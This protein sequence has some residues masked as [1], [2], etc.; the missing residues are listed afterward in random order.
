M[1]IILTICTCW[2]AAF[3]F[4]QNLEFSSDKFSPGQDVG[5]TYRP[6]NELTGAISV[7]AVVFYYEDS[8]G[9]PIAKE[10][11][12]NAEGDVFKGNITTTEATK[13]LLIR[14]I[15]ED[16]SDFN[17]KKGYKVKMHNAL[18]E[19]VQGALAALANVYA[20][21]G[22]NF[23]IEA[24]TQKGYEYLTRELKLYPDSKS[25]HLD[26][27]ARLAKENND[28]N[29]IAEIKAMVAKL[30]SNKKASESDLQSARVI[31]LRLG[32][33]EAVNATRTRILKDY[34]KGKTVLGEK[35]SSFY[36]EKDLI[37]KE[38]IFAS[39]KKDLDESSLDRMASV[40]ATQ[41]KD[42]KTKF[43]TYAGMIKN[44]RTLAGVYNS[45]AWGLSGESIEGEARDL[46]WAAAL[47]SKSLELVKSA[48]E[49]ME[50]KPSFMTDSDW[51]KNLKSTYSM[52]ADT[53]AL[54]Q[55]KR[56]KYGDALR[57]QE[58]YNKHGYPSADATLRHA[59]YAE[60]V[61]GKDAALDIMAKAIVEGNSNVELKEKF[62]ALL[63]SLPPEE[64]ATKS[65]AFLEMQAMDKLKVEIAKQMINK[66]SPQFALKDLDGNEVSL[67]SLKGKTVVIDF[68]ATWCGPCI[69]SFPGM[70]KAVDKYKD[71]ASVRFL[72]VDSWERM[73]ADKRTDHVE[74][75]VENKGY[76]F[77]VLMDLDDK[78]IKSYGVEGIPT[79]FV[80]GPDGNIKFKKIGGGDAEKLVYELYTMIDLVKNNSAE[81]ES[82]SMVDK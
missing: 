39:I 50:G 42:N 28:E 66:E 46:D 23:G 31:Y 27:Y 73:G 6:A 17:S 16:K 37:K 78:V 76:R 22:R 68:W 82:L 57:Y 60:K 20:Y 81:G 79:K 59:T 14:F 11:E 61:K 7:S 12:L 18:G 48:L 41:Y 56:G 24:D 74:K 34:P 8:K 26:L 38:Q 25:Q 4:G 19:P 15:S 80:I 44:P 5:I 30:T 47:S 63:S 40:L 49:I 10:I 9:S 71:D 62:K 52:Y 45:L 54:I 75:F 13:I 64:A 69:A 1:K 65:L 29:A 43:E 67:A 2:V 53:Y 70:Q 32:D 21:S 33:N 58:I 55:F 77:Q 51:K 36:D 3:A 72:F 35:V